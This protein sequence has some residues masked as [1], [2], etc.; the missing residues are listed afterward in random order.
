MENCNDY[1]TLN[2][3]RLASYSI[4]YTSNYIASIN[5]LS[6]FTDKDQVRAT[7]FE[8]F[9]QQ[10]NLIFI[11][12]LFPNVLADIVLEVYFKR[13]FTFDDYI[14]SVKSYQVY[15]SE[16]DKSFFAAKIL[17]FVHY[18]LYSDIGSI[19][20]SN[21]ELNYALHYL[22][23]DRIAPLYFDS[24]NYLD[25]IQIAL[26]T[27]LLRIDYDKSYTTLQGDVILHFVIEFDSKII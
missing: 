12:M 24:S 13:V 10:N 26:S 6:D 23:E 21:G 19:R 20:Y 2:T 22:I 3:R 7:Q 1:I 25:L 14:Q 11:D 5:Q 8:S 18:L 9:N 27:L 17:T 4:V 16:R 15:D